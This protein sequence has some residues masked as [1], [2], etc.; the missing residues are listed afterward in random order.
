MNGLI[1]GHL[2][3][4]YSLRSAPGLGDEMSDTPRTDAFE[5]VWDSDRSPIDAIYFA[6]G[7]E[8]EL[9]AKTAELEQRAY[10]AGL[11]K[12]AEII[13]DGVDDKDCQVNTV[14]KHKAGAIRAL[15]T[16]L[17]EKP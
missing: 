12:A 1:V 6:R 10:I 3:D 14:L 9:A 13:L 7:L 8:L 2:R 17:K 11:E 5:E 15:A 16:S 4:T